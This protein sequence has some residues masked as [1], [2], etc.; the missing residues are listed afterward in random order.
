MHSTLAI[1]KNESIDVLYYR[2]SRFRSMEDA[3]TPVY[4]IKF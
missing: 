3:L 1:G 2:V 4:T